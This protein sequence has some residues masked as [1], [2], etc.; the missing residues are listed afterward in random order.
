M[1]MFPSCLLHASTPVK[2]QTKPN[3]KGMGKYT[4]THFYL[5][6]PKDTIVGT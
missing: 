3:K 5:T 1:A 4:I 2:F 6:M